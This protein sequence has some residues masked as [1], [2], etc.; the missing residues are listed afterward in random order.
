MS[1]LSHGQ[2][3]LL[4]SQN[5]DVDVEDPITHEV[6]N[7]P[8][9]PNL[10]SHLF[11]LTHN[12]HHRQPPLH[13][14]EQHLDHYP[15]Q[16]QGRQ[17]HYRHQHYD[18]QH[19]PIR[20]QEQEVN[21]DVVDATSA[22]QH[23][24]AVIEV[25][26]HCQAHPESIPPSTEQ[27]HQ[28][29][30]PR[31]HIPVSP[32]PL[33]HQRKDHQMNLSAAYIQRQYHHH[34]EQDR[35][36]SSEN[37]MTLS[38][39]K[40]AT[41]YIKRN[42]HMSLLSRRQLQVSEKYSVISNGNETGSSKNEKDI[43]SKKNTKR[44]QQQEIDGEYLAAVPASKKSRRRRYENDLKFEV[45]EQLKVPHSK[46]SDVAKRYSIPENTLRDW[47]K[48]NVANTIENARSIN[49]GQLKVR[50]FETSSTFFPPK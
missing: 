34:Q 37:S 8:T 44:K 32:S 26:L 40:K 23:D 1:Y 3:N 28:H 38:D 18:V 29:H 35:S 9:G 41:V 7:L 14:L 25:G 4:Q 33:V 15:Q 19:H 46:L 39:E 31:Y 2:T 10:T 45:L 42:S 12:L 22:L 30:Y 50:A 13:H 47:R 16:G 24:D 43:D 20:Q 27:Q 6:D 49:S 5:H 11:S 17:F 21:I 48:V 36:L